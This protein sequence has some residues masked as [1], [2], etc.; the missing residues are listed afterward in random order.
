MIGGS[1]SKN[2][3]SLH[4]EPKKRLLQNSG[5]TISLEARSI[6]SEA[7]RSYRLGDRVTD[8]IFCRA[9]RMSSHCSGWVISRINIP[10]IH[11]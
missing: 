11:T 4:I 2:P 3:I 9:S 8:G 5:D 1:N 10:Y 6:F 7:E